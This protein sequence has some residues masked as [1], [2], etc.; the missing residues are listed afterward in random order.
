MTH[1]DVL[2][3][4]LENGM[5]MSECIISNNNYSRKQI[6]KNIIKMWSINQYFFSAI[7][8]AE[9]YRVVKAIKLEKLQM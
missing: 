3:M 2:P 6:I 5:R 4:R 1:F 9:V 7:Y 8:I